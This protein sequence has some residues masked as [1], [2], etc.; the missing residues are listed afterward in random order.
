MAFRASRTLISLRVSSRSTVARIAPRV[1]GAAASRVHIRG[2]ATATLT[3]REIKPFEEQVT[4][5]AHYGPRPKITHDI[6]DLSPSLVD[7]KVVIAGWLFSQRRASD[8]LHFFTL[9]SPSSSSAVQLVSRDKDVSKD[10]MEYPLESV[11]LVQ[12]TVKAR[13]QKAKAISSAVDEIELE[14]QGVT[15]LNPADQT[16]PFYPNRPEVANEDLRA[17]HRYL[18]LRRQDLADNLKTR[19]KVAHIIR[20]YL[21]DQ[22]FTEI[23]TP[24]LLNSSPEGAREF[25]V[26]TRS[27]TP[28]GGQ[29][30][31]YALPQSPQ[32]PKQLLVSSG[33]IPKYYQIAKCFRDEDGRRDRQPEFTQIDL[34][35]GFVSG[36]A[37]PPKGEGEMRSTWAIGGQEVRDVVEG[38]IKKIWKE[39]KGVDLEGWFRVMP[40]EVAMDVYGSDKP[41]TRFD[42]Y[43]LPIGYYPTLSDD[44]L[45]KVL[46]DQNPYTVE[47]MVTPAAQA[48]GLDIPSIAGNN[49]FIDY[50]K[51]TNAN[52]HSWLGESVLT[53]SLGLSLDKSLPGGVNP[54]DV[55][56]LSRRK[57]IAEGGWTHLGRLRVQL[58]EALVAKG[59]MTLPTQ[60]HFLWITQFPLFTLA[61][62]DKIHLSRGR[63]SSTHH[64]FTAP[65]YEDLADLK[66]GKIEGVRGQHY[67]LVLDGQEIGGGSVRIHDARLQEWVMKEV[68][69]LDEQEMGRFD[70]LLR[71]L[72]C[73]APP[74]GGL[75]LGFDRLVAILCGAKS[76]R[77]VIA[78]P[79]S[80]TG[81]D[82]VFKSP[83]VSGNEVLKEYGLQSLK[84]EEKE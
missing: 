71:A 81:Q 27:P 66:A 76:I 68:L 53:A 82:P 80:T 25:L 44:S 45:D 55:I 35:M 26:P 52:T 61:D 60:P 5:K 16:L 8:N 48:A 84:R 10:V 34:E 56:W 22:G 14:V 40:Y 28:E 19:S 77:D 29:P 70:H 30:T 6:A 64:P 74:H 9:R 46:L 17:Q 54:G 42:M 75:A 63:Y 39:V 24:I 20:N 79:K 31:F 1:W 49:S 13:R 15:L 78:F 57:K 43:T 21:H 69:Q 4:L 12:G 73:G 72:K 37:E 62:E 59:L 36:A 32:Q 11:V 3:P 50:V 51:I 83:S 18:D 23:E 41:D 58:M 47:W 2:N 67:D 38:M 65:M 7:Q 33:A